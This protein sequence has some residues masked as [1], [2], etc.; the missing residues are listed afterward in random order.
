[1]IETVVSKLAQAKKP[2][3]RIDFRVLAC[4]YDLELFTSHHE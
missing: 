4:G 2:G 3:V 1:L